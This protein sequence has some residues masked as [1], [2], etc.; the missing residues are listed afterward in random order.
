MNTIPY[1]G[2]ARGNMNLHEVRRQD[3]SEPIFS[4]DDHTFPNLSNQSLAKV[5]VFSFG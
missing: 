1:S 5:F 4:F 2:R 3:K